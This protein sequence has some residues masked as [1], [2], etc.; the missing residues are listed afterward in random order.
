MN[1]GKIRKLSMLIVTAS[2]IGM[3]GGCNPNFDRLPQVDVDPTVIAV[4]HLQEATVGI[5][6]LRIYVL[7]GK[8]T[9]LINGKQVT[10]PSGVAVDSKTFEL[11]KFDIQEFM[12]LYKGKIK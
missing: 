1:T 3:L 9:V 6:Q 8:Y 11:Y 4:T 5:S 12:N 10:L 2:L 7:E